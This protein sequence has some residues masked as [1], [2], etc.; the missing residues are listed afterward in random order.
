MA[1]KKPNPWHE[2]DG[3]MALILPSSMLEHPNFLRL[4][5][6]AVKLLVDLGR[7]YKGHNNG[8]LCCSWS[9]MAKRGWRSNNTVRRAMHELEH[10]GI[11]LRSKQGGKNVATLHAL[12]WRNIN[13]QRGRVLD[14]A[15]TLT[16]HNTWKIAV[17][18]FVQPE[19]RRLKRSAPSSS[20][21]S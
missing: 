18:D 9:A 4:S 16:P 6:H 15:M 3:G 11:I 19:P 20:T 17:P 8:Y 21:V 7:Q 13:E 2:I 1:K 5:A 14:I 12:S 10:Y